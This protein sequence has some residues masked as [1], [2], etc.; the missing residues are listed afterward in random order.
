MN[1]TQGK[2]VKRKTMDGRLQAHLGKQLR[3]LFVECAR[4][5]IPDQFVALLDRLE[6]SMAEAEISPEKHKAAASNEVQI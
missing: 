4:Q 2:P 3:Q 6:S 1:N 5:P